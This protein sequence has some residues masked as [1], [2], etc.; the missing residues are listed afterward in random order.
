[1]SCE[2]LPRFKHAKINIDVIHK[3]RREWSNLPISIIEEESS[4]KLA[5][6]LNILVPINVNDHNHCVHNAVFV[7][8]WVAYQLTAAL[9][10]YPIKIKNMFRTRELSDLSAKAAL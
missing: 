10:Q 9:T 5:N 7:I 3:N 4:E 8:T 6:S 1:M 2:R